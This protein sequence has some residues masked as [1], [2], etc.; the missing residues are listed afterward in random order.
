MFNVYW[1]IG[2]QVCFLNLKIF[3]VGISTFAFDIV[4]KAPLDMD[5][6]GIRKEWRHF[7]PCSS[8]NLVCFPIRCPTWE[9][10]H[11]FPV[12]PQCN[13]IKSS[14]GRTTCRHGR[15]H[16]GQT[17]VTEHEPI[18]TVFCQTTCI[19]DSGVWLALSFGPEKCCQQK[20]TTTLWHRCC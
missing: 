11:A 20:Y 16:G 2:I 5:S 12:W 9:A 13:A 10:G 15:W 8:I 19:H 1:S 7:I 6:C 14:P 17:K 3:A 4:F 18:R